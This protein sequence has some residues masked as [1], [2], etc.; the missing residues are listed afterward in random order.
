LFIGSLIL[1]NPPQRQRPILT[2]TVVERRI[3]AHGELS[4]STKIKREKEWMETSAWNERKRVM[5][6][7][8]FRRLAASLMLALGP[9]SLLTGPTA[10]AQAT[11]DISKM[12]DTDGDGT[13]S[14]GEAKTA[15]GDAFD[16]LDLNHDGE[17]NNTELGGRV[18]LLDDI[19]PCLGHQF[20][21]WKKERKLNK[22]QYLAIVEGRFRAVSAESGGTCDTKALQTMPGQSLLELLTIAPKIPTN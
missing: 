8:I 4:G 5:N 2:E 18:T 12:V 14:L 7:S 10:L 19:T 9:L 15:A 1:L 20:Y 21:F 17:L 13:I 16:K 3:M 6:E 22:D 11:T